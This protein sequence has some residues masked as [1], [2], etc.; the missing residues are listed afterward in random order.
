MER[1]FSWFP[2][3]ASEVEIAL[4]VTGLGATAASLL[5]APGPSVVGGTAGALC[6]LLL[7]GF[8]V[9][10]AGNRVARVQLDGALHGIGYTRVFRKAKRSLLLVHLD[11]D[12]PDHELL[13]LYHKLLGQGVAVRRLVFVRPDHRAEGIHWITE[14]EPHPLLR[15]RFVEVEAGSPLSLSLAIVDENVVLLAVPGFHATETELYAEGVVLRHLIELRHAAVTRAFL[16]VYE[17]AWKRATPFEAQE[18]AAQEVC[19]P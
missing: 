2:F 15:Q 9:R 5:G 1:E 10:A 18:R 7:V 12:A 3:T 8:M 13:A 14:M 6:A 4:G 16:E 17:S 19:K 11:D